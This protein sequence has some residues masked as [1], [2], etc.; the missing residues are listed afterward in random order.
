MRYVRSRASFFILSSFFFYYK[1]F[2]P[3]FDHAVKNSRLHHEGVQSPRHLQF[4]FNYKFIEN[5]TLFSN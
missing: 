3:N 1:K 5:W 4:T 2:D